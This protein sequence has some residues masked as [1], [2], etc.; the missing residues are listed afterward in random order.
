MI[1]ITGA[2][3]VPLNTCGRTRVRFRPCQHDDEDTN[4]GLL[5]SFLQVQVA[6][7]AS[8]YIH[9]VDWGSNARPDKLYDLVISGVN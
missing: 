9:V 8:I 1:E 4:A 7:G 5:D 3:G 6:A 2:N